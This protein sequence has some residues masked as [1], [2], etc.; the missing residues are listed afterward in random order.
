MIKF[1]DLR[2]VNARFDTL[3]LEAFNAFQDSGH[4]ILGKNVSAF[5]TNFASY[6]G[7]KYAIGVGNGL[8]AISLIFK[9]YISLGKLQIGDEVLV[10]ANTYIASILGVI[11]AGLK[12]VLV[13]PHID[14]YNISTSAVESEITSKT[15]AILAVHL[16]GQ[17]ADMISLQQISKQHNLLLIEDAAQAHG[18][19][20]EDGRRAGNLADAAAFSFY[21]SKNLGALGDG[22]AVT[23][24]DSAL[25]D[26]I[27]KLRNY[28][29]TSKYVNQFPGVNSRLDEIQALFLNI[30]LK[31]LDRDNDVRRK[32]AN[33]YLSNV[34]N[35]K[36]ILPL[37]PDMNAHVFHLFV[38]RVAQREEFIAYAKQ[39]R[40]ET[41]IHYPIPPHKQEAL[42]D[43]NSLTLPV[44]EQIHNTVVSLPISPVMTDQDVEYLIK[45]LNNY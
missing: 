15:K 18:A 19:M 3:F 30:K 27:K 29:T 35:N 33:R 16:Y 28:G 6:C 24:N 4:Y 2:K 39:H 20:L 42:Q 23:T 11:Q 34:K 21:P 40:I 10:P 38:V 5:E 43:F 37:C 14:S 22:G 17:L 25:A 45:V 26:T 31:Q 44:T 41:L 12:P 13:E 36:I 8:D 7:T 32:I 1:L 9:S